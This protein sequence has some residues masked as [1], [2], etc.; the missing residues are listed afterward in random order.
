MAR[1][2]SRKTRIPFCVLRAIAFFFQRIGHRAALRAGAALG[3]LCRLLLASKRRRVCSNLELAFPQEAG[4]DFLK[5]TEV[6]VFRHFG[7]MGAEFLRFP[8]LD[9]RWLREH[10]F[11]ENLD[12]VRQC[13]SEGR[14]VLAFIAH[15][16]NWELISKRLALE[17]D[18]PCHVVTRKIRDPNIDSF[19]REHRAHYGGA[20]S[21]CSEDAGIRAILKA[22]ARNEIVVLAVDQSAGPPEGIPVPFFGRL[23]GTHVGAGR[24]A[25]RHKL[26]LLPA[27]SCRLPC[28]SHRVRFGPLLDVPSDSSL[29]EQE[30]IVRLTSRLTGLVE[31][32]IREHPEQWIW[33]HNRWKGMPS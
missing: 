25:L 11:I 27:F 5:W 21:L 29:S 9:D 24:I 30:R 26:P 4:T 28:G 13:L 16:G 10:V 20:L 22:L 14:G 19:I 1:S 23:A 31:E 7:R 17:I 2:P 3:D 6:E 33:M 32:R 12:L 8:V 18:V 15:F